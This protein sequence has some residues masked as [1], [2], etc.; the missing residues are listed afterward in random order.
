[1]APVTKWGIAGCGKISSDFVNAIQHVGG[2]VHVVVA[3]AAR[4]L[5]SAEAFAKKF[6]I[7]KYYDRYEALAED[8][9]I[10]VVYIGVINTCHFGIARSMLSAKKPV[11]CEKPLCLNL[12]ET[13]QLVD[14]ARKQD[15]FLMEGIW[16]RYFPVYEELKTRLENQEVGDVFHAYLTFGVSIAS[17][18]RVSEKKYGGGAMLD[19]GVYALQFLLFVFGEQRPLEVK[20]TGMLNEQGLEV[21]VTCVLKFPGDRFGTF[22]ISTRGFLPN[23]AFVSGSKGTMKLSSPFWAPENLTG[24]SGDFASPLDPSERVYN[25]GNSQG[26]KYEAA[27]VAEG[28][29]RGEK[30][31]SRTPHSTTLLLAELI[32][33]IREQ[34]GVTC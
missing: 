12:P 22:V 3:V 19:I 31:I 11:L 28:L 15:T 13:Q 30:E 23:E 1:M 16:S 27:A 17:V 5:D 6:G 34:L 9:D 25:Y 33:T 26:F 4:S 20:A 7:G 8:P 2:S 14:F 29:R 32:Q 10:D 18:S 21:D 24:P